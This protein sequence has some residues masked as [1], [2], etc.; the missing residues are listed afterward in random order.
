MSKYSLCIIDDKIP[1]DI[2]QNRI[3]VDDTGIIDQNIFSNYVNF[4]NDE[5]WAD[6][7][8]YNLVKQLKEQ[9]EMEINL[10]GFKTH[11]FYLNYIDDY[12][13]SPDIIVFDWDVSTSAKSEVSLKAILKK[14][15]C[16]IAIYTEYDKKSEIESIIKSNDFKCFKYRLFIIGKHEENSADR[17][18]ENIKKHLTDFSFEYGK[19]IKH[20]INEAINTTFCKIRGLSF[21]Q[22]IKVFG[23]T[24]N[25]ESTKKHRISSLD[26]IEIMNEQIKA[27][28]LSSKAIKPLIATEIAEDAQ[29]EK[30]LWH[31]RML[32]K[33]Q[34]DIVRK[35]DI[36]WHKSKNKYFLIISS[37]CHL[38]EFWKK[39]IGFV[40]AVPLYK[41]NDTGLA[42]L[43]KKFIKKGTF[44]KY[45]LTS[46]VNQQGINITM[47][48]FMDNKDD[49]VVMLKSVETFTVNPPSDY[50]KSTK[51]YT[52]LQYTLMTDFD[53]TKRFRL[54]E[55]F[56]SALIESVLRNITDIGVPDYSKNI[57]SVLEGHIKN[58]LTGDSP[59]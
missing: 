37:D 46:L 57:Q 6:S 59:Q 38:N 47:I 18:I 13:F 10:S 17:V 33:P 39:N 11:S 50:D 35:G 4:Y 32:H 19:K 8:L 29:A 58:I 12:L 43:L 30:E 51:P 31:F 1:V 42:S 3:E 40:V 5:P 2:Y 20:N 56:L 21:N 54:N 27:H 24:F 23:E 41:A 45:T 25:E 14:T 15:Y 55:P 48:P 53:G 36:V 44:E 16:L 7:N 22:F 52:P 9:T 34:D 26:F 28:L 49:Y